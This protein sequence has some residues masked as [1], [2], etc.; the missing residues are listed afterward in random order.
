[1][2][3]PLPRTIEALIPSA[4]VCL[5]SRKARDDCVGS[6]VSMA[7]PSQPLTCMSLSAPILMLC[8]MPCSHISYED[9][10]AATSIHS[11]FKQL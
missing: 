11:L 9:P 4:N 2:D 10:S 6:C 3:Y 8:F 1:M 5:S 7:G